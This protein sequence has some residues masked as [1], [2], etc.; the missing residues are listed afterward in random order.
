MPIFRLA[1]FGLVAATVSGCAV[2]VGVGVIAARYGAEAGL[3]LGTGRGLT[4]HALTQLTGD[5]CITYRIFQGE[6]ICQEWP[7][8]D[9]DGDAVLD[10]PASTPASADYIPASSNPVSAGVRAP[11]P[12]LEPADTVTDSHDEL[13]FARPERTA[14]AWV[15]PAGNR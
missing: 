4:D 9:G 5:D 10:A 2:P 11:A 13:L 3:Y 12:R 14:S 15:I 1:A 7:P 8:V 6:T